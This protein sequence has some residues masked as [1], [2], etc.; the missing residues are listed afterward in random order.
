MDEKVVFAV[1]GSYETETLLGTEPF[2][3]ASGSLGAGGLGHCLRDDS[4][5]GPIERSFLRG[6][7][8]F[9]IFF[10]GFLGAPRILGPA[11]SCL[12]W[13]RIGGDRTVEMCGWLGSD[14][15]E[16]LVV[17]PLRGV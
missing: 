5:K 3:S 16:N 11:F 13:N 8:F 2:D 14:G 15:L 6:L 9:L 17:Y 4:G 10:C 7:F 1:V 12:F